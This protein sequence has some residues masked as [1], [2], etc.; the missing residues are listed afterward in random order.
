MASATA[1]Q[2]PPV[3]TE[4]RGPQEDTQQDVLSDPVVKNLPA[5]AGDRGSIPGL[6]KFHMLGSN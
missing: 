6:G 4:G 5:N 1:G 2:G 3:S